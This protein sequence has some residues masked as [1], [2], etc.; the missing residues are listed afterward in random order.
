M[1]C[2]M[3]AMVVTMTVPALGQQDTNEIKELSV[4]RAKALA[5]WPFGKSPE[6]NGLTTLSDV[7]AKWLAKPLQPETTKALA[8]PATAR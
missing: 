1:R 3:V 4:E 5:A 8:N 2:L 7:A 6:L